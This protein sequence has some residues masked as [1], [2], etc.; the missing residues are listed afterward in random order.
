MG[1]I[2]LAVGVITGGFVSA[3]SPAS[4]DGEDDATSHG[5]RA[6]RKHGVLSKSPY[7]KWIQDNK[8]LFESI[9]KDLSGVVAGAVRAAKARL[10][11]LD[12]E[13]EDADA[14]RF[15]QRFVCYVVYHDS[16]VEDDQRGAFVQWTVKDILNSNSPWGRREIGSG[17]ADVVT[18]ENDIREIVFGADFTPNSIFREYVY[19]VADRSDA[20]QIDGR[21]DANAPL[22]RYVNGGCSELTKKIVELKDER[23]HKALI[24]SGLCEYNQKNSVFAN[25]DAPQL[26]SL[27]QALDVIQGMAKNQCENGARE[28][29]DKYNSFGWTLR[30]VLAEHY[31]TGKLGGKDHHRYVATT[32]ILLAALLGVSYREVVMI[33]RDASAEGSEKV[34]LSWREIAREMFDRVNP[35][36]KMRAKGALL[37]GT[38][39]ANVM[40]HLMGVYVKHKAWKNEFE[41]K[42]D[43]RM[44]DEMRKAEGY[45][46]YAPFAASYL[47]MKKDIADSE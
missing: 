1:M 3:G 31:L 34:D 23:A 22:L 47:A 42:W 13:V 43:E 17:A 7:E 38:A 14:L 37:R 36:Q 30:R 18:T 45:D 25:A 21:G 46:S 35:F 10:E 15:L 11:E 12:A 6:P 32:S 24:A 9:G 41:Y 33:T 26:G 2:A 28:H 8:S 19:R 44:L 16:S 5:Y 40:Y 29:A 27:M 20:W 4:S 39:L